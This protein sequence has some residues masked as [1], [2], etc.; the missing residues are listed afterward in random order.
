M[1]GRESD[2]QQKNF[3]AEDIMEGLRDVFTK[4]TEDKFL[5]MLLHDAST[6]LNESL[7][8]VIWTFCPKVSFMRW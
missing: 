1:D 7:H 4:I 6:C 3:V 5:Q 2:F 8:S